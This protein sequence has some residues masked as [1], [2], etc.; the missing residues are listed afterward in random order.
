MIRPCDYINLIAFL[1]NFYSSD[2][3]L[4]YSHL[5]PIWHRDPLLS[6]IHFAGTEPLFAPSPLHILALGA[7]Q[8]LMLCFCL[9]FGQGPPSLFSSVRSYC[10]W[11]EISPADISHWFAVLWAFFISI[12]LSCRG[13]LSEA[14][15]LAHIWK[16][17]FQK[18]LHFQVFLQALGS[19]SWW[20]ALIVVKARHI[21]SLNSFVQRQAILASILIVGALQTLKTL[22]K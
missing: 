22:L 4:S 20:R 21:K 1:H 19:L 3:P 15:E 8:H 10:S 14:A 18:H 13:S 7:V 9:A 11:K 17:F 6:P 12:L 16:V 2:I 5:S